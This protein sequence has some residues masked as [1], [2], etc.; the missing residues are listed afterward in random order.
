MFSFVTGFMA[1]TQ[2]SALQDK[3]FDE[4]T[5]PSFM[6]FVGRD[7][8][9]MLLC[10]VPDRTTSSFLQELLHLHREE[11]VCNKE[12]FFFFGCSR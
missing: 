3:C 11:E 1:K 4:F 10:P 8:E 6:D 9:E 12:N 7:K 2:N 5:V